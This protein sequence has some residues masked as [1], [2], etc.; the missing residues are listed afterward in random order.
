MGSTPAVNEEEIIKKGLENSKHL[1]LYAGK[2]NGTDDIEGYKKNGGR[3]IF[4]MTSEEKKEYTLKPDESGVTWDNDAM[5]KL[6]LLENI[7]LWIGG[8][9][10]G[11]NQERVEKLA[12]IVFALTELYNFDTAS[13]KYL[14]NNNEPAKNAYRNFKWIEEGVPLYRAKDKAKGGIVLVIAAGPS[15]DAQWEDLARIHK[16]GAVVIVAGRTY[17]RAMKAGITPDF[18]VEVE[19]FEWDHAIFHFA[20]EPPPF[21]ILCGPLSTCPGVFNTWPR[22]KMIL[23]DH[24]TAALFGW[25]QGTESMDGGNSILHHMVNLATFLGADTVCLAG[26]DLSYP[27]GTKET[28]ADGTFHQGWPR[29]VDWMERNK[30]DAMQAPCT[31]GGMCESSPAYRNF[32]TYLEIQIEKARRMNN[33][34]KFINFSPHGQLI[35]GT[36]FQEIST[37]NGPSPSQ[38][39]LPHAPLRLDSYSSPGAGSLL[40]DSSPTPSS[41]DGTTPGSLAFSTMLTPVA[42]TTNSAEEAKKP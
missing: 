7:P 15:L 8:Q 33:K 42:S 13:V 18:V 27:K 40:P 12:A 19:Q 25:K 10:G 22:N 17:K 30:Q 2:P 11:N 34:L 41:S 38:S 5:V 31:S 14:H 36:E 20:P 39:A 29:I 9:I 1:L 32:A 24:N 26:A 28:H 37:W 35:N 21:T 3:I 16:L 23:V 4:F 6:F